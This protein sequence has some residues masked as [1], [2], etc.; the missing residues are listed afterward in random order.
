MAPIY[1]TDL[2]SERWK[3]DEWKH[4]ELWEKLEQKEQ[5]K[6][7]IWIIVT[8][9][10]FLILSSIPVFMDLAPKWKTLSLSR[11]FAVEMNRLKKDAGLFHQSYRIRFDHEDSLKY[12]IES[13]D[14]CDSKEWTLVRENSLS[15]I[16]DPKL[17]KIVRADLANEL[18]LRGLVT[19]FCYDVVS[20]SSE[21]SL[22]GLGFIPVNDLTIGRLDRLSIVFLKGQQ[23]EISFN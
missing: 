14:R 2:E 1:S 23:A 19:S 6:R 9:V 18:S 22:T 7:R 21:E 16:A 8:A 12:V 15:N 5:R 10:V 11:H 17:Y 20:G 13:A 3:E 4:L